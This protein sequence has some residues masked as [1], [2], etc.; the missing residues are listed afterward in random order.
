MRPASR[1]PH[2]RDS[3]TRP[4]NQEAHC[5]QPRGLCTSC[6]HCLGHPSSRHPHTPFPP[7][8]GVCSNATFSGWPTLTPHLKLHP[9]QDQ[10]THRLPKLLLCWFFTLVLSTKDTL[11]I[12][13]SV[14]PREDRVPI[15]PIH[16]SISSTQNGGWHTVGSLET[17]IQ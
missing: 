10:T 5:K 7:P 2:P 11:C 17:I 12:Q 3:C 6:S 16:S 13:L 4:A 1:K 14:W 15:R 8:A 9:P